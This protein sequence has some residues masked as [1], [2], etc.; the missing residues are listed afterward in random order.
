MISI[1]PESAVLTPIRRPDP[2]G[3]LGRSVEIYVNHF[4]VSIPDAIINQYEIEITMIRRDGR[5]ALARKDERW[6]TLQELIR[7]EKN[8]PLVWFDRTNRFLFDFRFFNVFSFRRY[9]EGRTLYTK[10][11]LTDFTQPRRVSLKINDEE[12]TFQFKV[13][14]LVRQ[15]KIGN[16]N[17]FLQGRLAQNPREA[18]RVIE[19][20]LKQTNRN[21]YL[22]V[23][24]KYF[25]RN[26]QMIDLGQMK[27]IRN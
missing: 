19:I 16:I 18:V 23:G 24:Y 21:E 17:E 27:I 25:P 15:E 7:K 3:N 14:N 5:E 4:S 13:L 10:D 8:F 2:H 20:L 12:K 9:D 1:V 6:E 26:Q 11:L 22:S